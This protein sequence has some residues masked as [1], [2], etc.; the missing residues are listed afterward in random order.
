MKVGLGLTL[1]A[2]A[3]SLLLAGTAAAAPVLRVAVDQAGDF[4]LIGSTLGHECRRSTPAPIVGTV[5]SCGTVMDSFV[6]SSPD[7][8]WRADASGG[9]ASPRG[10]ARLLAANG[11]RSCRSG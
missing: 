4:A 5:G 2:A 7:I 10:G 1:L 11:R 9:R 6:D 8:F 3:G